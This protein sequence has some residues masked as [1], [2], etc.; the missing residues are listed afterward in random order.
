LCLS[1][2]TQ[3]YWIRLSPIVQNSS[4]LAKKPGP[5]LSPS[6]ADRP[7][8]PAKDHRLGELLPHQ[9]P[10]PAQAYP[11][12]VFNFLISSITTAKHSLL[13]N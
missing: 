2:F 7:L 12:A 6:V 8:R 5:Y 11:K 3:H 13:K 10:N 4:L 9:L 1:S